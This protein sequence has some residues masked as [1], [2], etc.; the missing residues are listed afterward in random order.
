MKTPETLPLPARIL[1]AAFVTFGEQ[2][3]DKTSMDA[4]AAVA[5]TTKRTVYAHFTNKETLFRASFKQAA[6]WF[7]AELPDLDP[8]QP[9]ETELAHFAGRFS[10]LTTWRG[11]VRL[12]RVAIS[13][14][15]RLPDLAEMMHNRV[16]RGAEDRIMAFLLASGTVPSASEESALRLARLFLN[17]ATGAKRFATLFEATPPI[18]D[19]PSAAGFGSDEVWIHF[20]VQFFLS[21][22]SGMADAGRV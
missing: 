3:Y 9:P 17:M 15:E 5:S 4:V 2:G 19:H 18:P 21:G 11:P 6:E 7:L 14:A 16:I 13:E 10:D 12:Q 1:K 20:A 8:A 22:L